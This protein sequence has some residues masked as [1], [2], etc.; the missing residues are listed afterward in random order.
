MENYNGAIDN[1]S[2]E[3]KAKNYKLNEVCLAP[4]PVIWLEKTPDQWKK[5]PTIRNQDGSGSCVCQTYATELSILFEQKYGVW[6]DFSST[7]PY[8]L[9]SQPMI[10]GCNST[11]VYS[12]FPK[13]GN[14]FERDMPSMLM[15]DAGMMAV[16][17]E[18]YY[19]DY[20]KVWKTSRIELPLDFETVASTIQSTGKGVM[21]WV[22]FH[23]EEWTD[24]PTVGTKSP[25][26]GHSITAIDYFLIN[27]KKYILIIDSWGSNY[28]IQGYRLIS[29]EYFN[30]R[31]FLASYLKTFNIQ[32][33]DIIP[34][35]PKFDGSIISF[36]KCMQWLGFFPGNITPIE[37]FGAISRSACIKYQLARGITPA[38]GNLG[39][40]TSA[41]LA[42]EFK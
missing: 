33:N 3:A 19:D 5:L 41:R 28:A 13:L 37:N 40:I 32:D 14:V 39:P 11:D 10:S 8:Q 22:K 9:R 12:I 30:A 20:A 6:V 25:T 27:G 17:K 35:R 34:E 4:A 38:L 29:E 21:I 36:Q 26:S 15:N 18:K 1:Q 23:P 16:K 2:A 7:F 24:K 42:E 31:C